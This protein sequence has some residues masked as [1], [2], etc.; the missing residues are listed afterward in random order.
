MIKILHSA[1]IVAMVCLTLSCRDIIQ[2]QE[3]NDG[4]PVS[5]PEQQGVDQ[6]KVAAAYQK[7]KRLD[8]IYS[9]LVVKNGF[10]IAEKYFNGQD[11]S[12]A[13][14]TA[15]VTKSFTSAL[16]GIA[17]R[18]GILSGLDSKLAD[19][20]LEID[21][22]AVDPRKS[23]ITIRQ[24]L[25]MRSG[26]PWEETDG[27]L[28]DLFSRS[29]WIPLLAE[30][31]LMADP[32]ARWGY[33]NFMSHMMAVILSRAAGRSLLAFAQE[34][35]FA[36]L[37]ITV[38]YWPQDANGYYYGMGDMQFTPRN[39]ARF[40]QLYLDKG[41]FNG[42]QVIP[43][44]WI[45]ASFQIYSPTTYGRE[46]MSEIRQLGYG[47]FWWSAV[48][49]AHSY[50]YAWGHGGQMIAVIGDLNMVIVAT[51]AP[52]WGFDNTA[53]QKEKAVLELVGRL[54]ASL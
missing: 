6:G 41:L 11:I 3:I 40:G 48:S 33:S 29:N 2:P 31:P 35:L 23:Q 34:F 25:Q 54:I 13:N 39:L 15:S 17:L 19:F 50:R 45:E 27:Y 1:L 20:F 24:I 18:E 14:P 44:E 21:W 53:W 9:L 51:A 49:G 22:Q 43:A 30:F 42:R 16:A 26:Y 8:N 28:D 7:A 38:A 5:T 36:P 37:E 4:W 47:Y 46:I 12:R 52:Q 32:G 10:L